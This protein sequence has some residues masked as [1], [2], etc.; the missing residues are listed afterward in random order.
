MN[1]YWNALTRGSGKILKDIKILVKKAAMFLN[2][3][4]FLLSSARRL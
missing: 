4:F 1:Q 3:H 2:D